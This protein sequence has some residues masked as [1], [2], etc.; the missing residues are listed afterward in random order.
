MTPIGDF[1]FI[2]LVFAAFLY[3]LAYVLDAIFAAITK[4]FRSRSGPQDEHTLRSADHSPRAMPSPIAK[5]SEARPADEYPRGPPASE[6]D[7]HPHER[8]KPCIIFLD[9]ETTGLSPKD[10]IV[11]IGCVAIKA[12]PPV[13]RTHFD[14]LHLIFDPCRDCHPKAAQVHGYDDWTLGHQETFRIR[15]DEVTEFLSQ[16]GMVV[17]HN[18][19]FDL[20]FIDRELIAQ[21]KPPLSIPSYCTMEAYRSEFYARSASLSAISREIGL[22]RSRKH[23]ALEDAWL[24]MQ[25][26]LWIRAH[27]LCASDLSDF[28]DAA[29]T[30][31]ITPPPKPGSAPKK[32]SPRKKPVNEPP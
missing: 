32:R 9:V 5:N 21:G 18:A 29:P 22:K 1:I 3:V 30:N 15:C 16:A 17:A 2:V 19:S 6:P 12:L 14:F 27:P 7:E 13:D 26:F 10:K 28:V 8:P 4:P 11:S 23:S 20:S 25:A 24:A 31:Y